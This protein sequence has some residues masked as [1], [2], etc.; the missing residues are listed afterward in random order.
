MNA[1]DR[2]HHLLGLAHSRH[3]LAVM[4]DHVVSPMDAQQTVAIARELIEACEPRNSPR[5]ARIA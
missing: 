2:A 3:P 4:P 5:A 1:L